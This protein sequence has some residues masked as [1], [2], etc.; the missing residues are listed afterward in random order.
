MGFRSFL[1]RYGFLLLKLLPL[2]AGII[3][4]TL[5]LHSRYVLGPKDIDEFVL[6]ESNFTLMLAAGMGWSITLLGLITFLVDLN[7]PQSATLWTSSFDWMS[8]AALGGAYYTGAVWTLVEEDE[9][10]SIYSMDIWSDYIKSAAAM[11]IIACIG[12]W[13]HAGASFMAWWRA[14][15]QKAAEAAPSA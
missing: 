6:V 13:I 1:R 2:S 7:R 12:H 5:I 9:I 15:T 11:G 4:F 3:A 10:L 8:H 14:P